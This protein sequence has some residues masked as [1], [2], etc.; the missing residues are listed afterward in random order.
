[1]AEILIPSF[2]D[3]WNEIFANQSGAIGM[4]LTAIVK[5]P[6]L[7][8][9]LNQSAMGKGCSAAILV[10]HQV[11]LSAIDAIESVIDISAVTIVGVTADLVGDDGS[12]SEL[13]NKTNAISGNIALVIQPELFHYDLFVEIKTLIK[14]VRRQCLV[15][16]AWLVVNCPLDSEAVTLARISQFWPI[17]AAGKGFAVGRGAMVAQVD[18]SV[19]VADN[20]GYK[21]F[22]VEKLRG[23]TEKL[24]VMVIPAAG[25]S[26]ALGKALI[27]REIPDS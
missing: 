27:V 10:A 15:R 24:P 12:F 7:R 6:A 25:K 19:I 9:V 1:M 5:S 18:A 22:T 14:Q 4:D 3:N 26:G 16:G 20:N 21:T 13:L 8:H 11:A 2:R 17:I 23:S